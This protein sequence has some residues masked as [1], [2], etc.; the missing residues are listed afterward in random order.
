MIL[1]LL[2]Y[3]IL[4]LHRRESCGNHPK[5]SRIRLPVS[6]PRNQPVQTLLHLHRLRRGGFGGM[7]PRPQDWE[8]LVVGNETGRLKAA[9]WSHSPANHQV[10]VKGV[11]PTVPS[12]PSSYEQ[13]RGT[14]ERILSF[15]LSSSRYP[16]ASSP[17]P[18]CL[19]SSSIAILLLSSSRPLSHRLT[20][21]SRGPY[22]ERVILPLSLFLCL[23][24]LSFR[25]LFVLL[26]VCVF[27]RRRQWRPS[28][29]LTTRISY[30]HRAECLLRASS[31][32]DWSV[33]GYRRRFESKPQSRRGQISVAEA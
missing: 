22:S 4:F 32:S 1:F 20:F 23:S 30:C 7:D 28:L 2:S 29:G 5:V 15:S 14:R 10:R 18:A 8:T 31:W 27:A 6:S 26:P 17:I 12:A 3:L 9:P 19:L 25:S 24:L 11:S 21:A 16:L 13:P 33:R